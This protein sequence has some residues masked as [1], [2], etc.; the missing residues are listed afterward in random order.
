M[1]VDGC[2]WSLW[3]L[4]LLVVVLVMVVVVLLLVVVLSSHLK[5]AQHA[6][7]N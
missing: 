1:V 4:W 6:I 2:W 7:A 5:N 3:S